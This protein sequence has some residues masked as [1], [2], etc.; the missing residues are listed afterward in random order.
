MTDEQ[1]QLTAAKMV[2]RGFN[3]RVHQ[4]AKWDMIDWWIE[5]QDRNV[6]VAEYKYRD[7]PKDK[8]PTTWLRLT[9]WWAL[10]HAKQF[11]NAR[12]ALF[13]VEFTDG[14][15]Y[16]PVDALE[17]PKIHLEIG[18]REDRPQ[19]GDWDKYQPMVAIPVDMLKPVC[20]EED[21]AQIRTEA[22]LDAS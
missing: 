1:R 15:Y 16:V 4:F 8:Y 3:C 17:A 2:E 18:G 6:G 11:C 14:I 13:V 12:A 7:N 20:S 9:K 19:R 22:E 5:Y 21:W 10:R